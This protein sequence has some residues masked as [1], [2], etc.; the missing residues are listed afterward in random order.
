MGKISRVKIQW[1]SW[2]QKFEHAYKWSLC[3][4]KW[5]ETAAYG[6]DHGTPANQITEWKRQL[7]ENAASF[8]DSGIPQKEEPVDLKELHAKIGQQA[9]DIDFLN[10][11]L[12]KV[13]LLSAKP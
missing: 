5:P 6:A 9:L 2:P 1:E 8:F 10:G 4:L 3:C 7:C 13:G 12:T 11:A